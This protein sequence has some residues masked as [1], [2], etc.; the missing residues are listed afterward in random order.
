MSGNHNF[1]FFR[2]PKKSGQVVLHIGQCHFLHDL[3]SHP[4]QPGSRLGFRNDR[5]HLYRV[6]RDV[7]EHPD[8]SNTQP[9]LGMVDPPKP[10][11][12]TLAHSPWLMSK[13]S[14]QCILHLRPRVG[15]EAFQILRG[16][17]GKNYIVFHSGHNIARFSSHVKPEGLA[18]STGL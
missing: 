9:I 13:V 12:S 3:L 5:Q 15:L 14:L 11:N 4:F 16:F 10:L 8:F 2:H 17:G 7:I 6:F 1:F 18:W